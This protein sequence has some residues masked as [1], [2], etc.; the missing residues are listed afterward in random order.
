MKMIINH[1]QSPLPAFE[2]EETL[3]KEIEEYLKK[4][5]F[6]YALNDPDTYIEGITVWFQFIGK[7]SYPEKSNEI[8][9]LSDLASFLFDT[10]QLNKSCL[11]FIFREHI[12]NGEGKFEVAVHS[13]D[14]V[15]FEELTGEIL[16]PALESLTMSDF[17][18]RLRRQ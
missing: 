18:D 16:P 5:S 17:L 7:T 13:L 3:G 2:D 9:S 10:L 11:H 15:V 6:H 14:K 12:I 1:P 8:R 4:N